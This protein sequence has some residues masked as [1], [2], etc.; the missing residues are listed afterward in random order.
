VEGP[1]LHFSA[2]LPPCTQAIP[3]YKDTKW[4][5]ALNILINMTDKNSP[6]HVK[7][8]GHVGKLNVQT[9]YN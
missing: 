3:S 7:Q 5:S 1:P 4:H 2:D 6:T 9:V 8:D